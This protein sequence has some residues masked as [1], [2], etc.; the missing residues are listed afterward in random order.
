MS[1]CLRGDEGWI[2]SEHGAEDLK[3]IQKRYGGYRFFTAGFRDCIIQDD[4]QRYVPFDQ[5]FGFYFA[6]GF[7]RLGKLN[8]K[9]LEKLDYLIKDLDVFATERFMVTGGRQVPAEEKV[10]T[11]GSYVFGG[12]IIPKRILYDTFIRPGDLERFEPYSKEQAAEI[13]ERKAR[14]LGGLYDEHAF[15]N[16]RIVTLDERVEMG[17]PPVTGIVL[18]RGKDGTYMVTESI[19]LEHAAKN[20]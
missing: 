16:D 8:S 7:P 18:S 10:G 3:E 5:N 9:Q 19:P 1:V 4:A 17:R 12:A 2:I 14:E 13:I 20:R 11:H 6:E 15:S